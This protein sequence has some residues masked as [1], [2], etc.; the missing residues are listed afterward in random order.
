MPWAFQMA[1][2][3]RV[4]PP[5]TMS[6]FRRSGWSRFCFEL[7]KIGEPELDQRPDA[8]LDPAFTGDLER[9]L[10]ALTHLCGIDPLLQA[11]V[12]RQQRLLYTNT[13]IPFH[14]P[15]LYS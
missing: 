11:V 1:I 3:F 10:V 8:V 5:P 7:R 9:L 6:G 2:I 15:Q 13:Q 12:P 14:V 4:L